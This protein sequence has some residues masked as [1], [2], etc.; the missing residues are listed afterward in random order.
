MRQEIIFLTR[1][2]G[3]KKRVSVNQHEQGTL[4]TIAFR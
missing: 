2:L 4:Y 3:G 1:P